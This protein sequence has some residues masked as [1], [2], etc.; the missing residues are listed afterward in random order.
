MLIITIDS[1]FRQ[2]R[3]FEVFDRTSKTFLHVNV[4]PTE[5][6]LKLPEQ[7]CVSSNGTFV[8]AANNSLITF[9][10][11][12]VYF[13]NNFPKIYLSDFQLFNESILHKEKAGVFSFPYNKNFFTFYFSAL[14]LTQPVLVNY[15]Y[16]LKGLN[17]KWI[18]AGKEGKADYTNLPPGTYSFEVKVSNALGNWSEPWSLVS[19]V[20]NPPFWFCCGF[21][22]P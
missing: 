18:E 11:D 13:Q 2:R 20:V 10:P 3:A 8:Y 5:W 9:N 12:S 6:Q 15:Q 21:M 17:D 16:R 14:E 19:F 1:G 4:Y 22:S 7:M